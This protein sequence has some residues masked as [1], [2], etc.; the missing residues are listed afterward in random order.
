MK[1]GQKITRRYM[2]IVTVVG[3][4][5]MMMFLLGAAR[6]NRVT[7]SGTLITESREVNHFDRLVLNGIGE[8]VITQGEE[9]SLTVETDDN[10][11]P[12]ITTEVRWGTLY[13]EYDAEKVK[14]IAPTQLHFTVQLTDLEGLQLAGSGRMTA[15]TINTDHLDIEMDGSGSVQIDLLTTEKV[16]VEMDGTGKVELAGK[17][18]DQEIAISGSGKYHAGDV[19]SKTVEISIN[20]SGDAVVWTTEALEGNINGSGSI[21]YYGSPSVD[22]FRAGS[23]KVKS[24]G[25]HKE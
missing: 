25:G 2:I 14:R 24:L 5:T 16:E 8:V 15:A 6:I 7:G 11:L 20:G 23:G 13:L 3:T 19:Q 18:T 22:I 10:I 4:V 17:A 21:K 1:N 9:E 12:Y